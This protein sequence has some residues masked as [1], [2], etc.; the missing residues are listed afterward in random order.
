[1]PVYY[2]QF[3]ASHIE[4]PQLDAGLNQVGLKLVFV[5]KQG[6][7]PIG[8]EKSSGKGKKNLLLK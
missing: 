4:I 1:L 5:G 3:I 2:I 7:Q 8:K 6:C